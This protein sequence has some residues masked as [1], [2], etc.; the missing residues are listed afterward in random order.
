M[1]YIL[2]HKATI[3]AIL[4]IIAFFLSVYLIW[5]FR[6]YSVLL[7]IVALLSLKGIMDSS[8]CGTALLRLMITGISIWGAVSLGIYADK[9][10]NEKKELSALD[11]LRVNP[12]V[13]DCRSFMFRYPNS[14]HE[15]EIFAI[16]Y[17]CAE[18][19][20]L[21]S[22]NR[23]ANDYKTNAWGK[24]ASVRVASICDSLYKVADAI[25]SIQAWKEFRS[26]VPYKYYA[27]SQKKM[28][29]I[30]DQ[31]WNTEQKAWSRASELNTLDA[32]EK[33]LS[34]YPNGARRNL[35]NK[36]M[37]D[38]QVANVFDKE[39]GELPTMNQTGYAG[40]SSSQISVY[41]NT[42]YT[43]TLLYSGPNSKSIT[44]PSHQTKSVNLKNGT[45]HIAASVIAPGVRNYAGTESLNGGIYSVE[46]Y[47]VT[48][49]Y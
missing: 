15:E 20:G 21:A 25:H 30:E 16:Y 6:G 49:R 3:I 28:E 31:M 5:G 46:Y 42:S 37:I 8:G 23:F 48:S 34:L 39:H 4:I 40:G 27:D 12:S 45:Y 14:S 10:E 19:G 13:E 2:E 41:N 47:I 36:I 24:K 29:E 17:S 33:Y 1:K 7:W 32:Y 26:V 38:L 43:L 11:S 35:A 9:L 22:L 44:I 18:A